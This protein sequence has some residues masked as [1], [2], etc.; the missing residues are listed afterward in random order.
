MF[1]YL[2]GSGIRMS[3]RGN[4]NKISMMGLLQETEKK[5]KTSSESQDKADIKE[6]YENYEKEQDLLEES[7]D[8][9]LNHL[10]VFGYLY[11]SRPSATPVTGL[12]CSDR[13]SY[14]LQIVP[15]MNP[16]RIQTENQTVGNKFY[17]IDLFICNLFFFSL[18]FV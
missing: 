4:Q 2:S 11:F 7:E 3:Y 13:I 8:Y 10:D 16:S 5:N 12:M 6:I 9:D 1:T 15:V 17:Q 14:Y 18:F